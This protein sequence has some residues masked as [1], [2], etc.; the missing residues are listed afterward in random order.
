MREAVV[1]SLLVLVAGTHSAEAQHIASEP[2]RGAPYRQLPPGAPAEAAGLPAMP[3]LA[4]QEPKMMDLA[5]TGL[6]AS[7]AG[8]VGG[9][10]AGYWLERSRFGWSCNCDDPGLEGMIYGAILGSALVTPPIVHESNGRRGNLALSLGG[11][12][13][14]AAISLAGIEASGGGDAGL[15]FILGPPLLQPFSAAIIEARTMRR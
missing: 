5:A 9:A 12:A 8:F 1:A 6:L 4:V 7:A 3:R 10:I 2:A 13:A 11:A 14:I 15:L